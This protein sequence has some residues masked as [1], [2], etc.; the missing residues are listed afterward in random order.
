MYCPNCS[1]EV[2]QGSASCGRCGAVM[3]TTCPACGSAN[4]SGS[5]FC[6]RC[7][8][9]LIGIGEKFARQSLPVGDA[10][11]AIHPVALAERRQMTVMF[12]D[13]VGSTA[14]SSM[15]DP[16]DVREL[17]VA[18]HSC[19]RNE[20]TRFG[21]VA[22]RHVGDG[23]LIY[24]GY[25]QAHEDDAARSIYAGLAA[26]E[27]VS[28][29]GRLG[30]YKPQIRIG[31]ATGL[32]VVGD[33]IG[34]SS[35]AE[36]DVVGQTPNLAARLQTGAEPGTLVICSAT[37]RLAGAFFEYSELGPLALKGFPEPS[38]AWR[39]LRAG[40]AQT[41]S[42]AQRQTGLTSLIG[43][44]PQLEVLERLWEAARSGRGQVVC[45]T[46]EAGIGK[47]RLCT[48]WLTQLGSEWHFRLRFYCSPHHQDTPFHP[49][50]RQLERAAGISREEP[51]SVKLQKLEAALVPGDRQDETAGL[52]A[53]LLSIP[54]NDRH[55]KLPA[56]PALCREKTMEV[57]LLQSELMSR[58]RPVVAV[59]E[60]VH[61]IDPTS[62][63]LLNR[64]VARTANLPLLLIVTCRPEF[65]PSWTRQPHVTSITLG[66]LTSQQGISLVQQVAGAGF[67]KPDIVSDIVERADG[68]PLYLEE[69]TKAIVES[70]P[71]D[72]RSKEMLA[73]ALSPRTDVP[74]TLHAS[75]MARL[76]R[77][78]AAKE[79]AQIGSAIGREFSY[80][81]L[82]AV[83][84]ADHSQLTLALNSLKA[85]GLVFQHRA[86]RTATFLFK[87]ALVQN[88]AYSTLLRS[89][90]QKL[91][92]RIA[93]VLESAFAE[94]ATAQ[95]ELLAHHYTEA[96]L[97][98][99]AADCWLNAGKQALARSA[100][101]EAIARLRRGLDILA[102]TEEGTDR[103][104]LELEFQLALG[105]ALIAT[106]GHAAP[107]TG[108]VFA[109][110]REVCEQLDRPPL[111]V[112]V[113][114]GQWTH[115]LLR[116]ELPAARQRAAELLQ[117]GEA[118]RDEI[119]TLMGCRASGVTCFPLG[120]FRASRTY[121]DRGLE[122]FDPNRR[123]LYTSL[124]V[125]DVQVVM[126]YYSSWSTLYLGEF[127]EARSR[128][129]RALA[130]ARQLG[131]PYSL[132]HVLIASCL[133]ELLLHSFSDVQQPL[134]EVEAL[135]A[136]HGIF[137]FGAIATIFRGRWLAALGDPGEGIE[138]MKRGI[139][140]LRA[141]GNVLYLPT[142][143]TFLADAYGKTANH[144]QALK[145]L[146]DAAEI[147]EATQ[148]RLDEPEMYRVRGE[149]LVA[150]NSPTD[151]E[152]HFRKA[153]ALARA[154][155]GRLAELRATVSL[156][157]L[158]QSKGRDSEAR[159]LLL[160]AKDW[161]AKG[162]Y[163]PLTQARALL[164]ALI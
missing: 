147:I 21:G 71:N 135:T 76:D 82:A 9:R 159:E 89:T 131:Q 91:H 103:L 132:A 42:E 57:L 29:L 143:L 44:E 52:L 148:T 51:A 155:A 73:R 31:V 97:S 88:A 83:A 13:L 156:G 65:K 107:I 63:E 61:W 117:S 154:Q 116:A 102:K 145:E 11:R 7:G 86:G 124:T 152:K 20:I 158:W 77:L 157:T 5:N 104:R 109:R 94:I 59:F 36:R 80:E 161:F 4:Q 10:L 6:F 70:G 49:C 18:F 99:K 119:W 55:F 15:F 48:S 134:E 60:D 25:P 118:R 90:R 101:A 120:E 16:E 160:P 32:V 45:V 151:A 56:T 140:A 17:I 35:V 115:A 67:L 37:Q 100:L 54:A 47:S 84:R 79:I 137:Y 27:A 93:E 22:A 111:F 122:L 33:I 123:S 66:A 58:Q 62:L 2:S 87:H 74:P 8:N 14:A 92:Q 150:L 24:F 23:G 3:A 96:G 46:G 144:E 50:I 41:T 39:V 128:C 28:R 85:A 141:S 164:D 1:S 19:V 105:K 153:I 138:L 40:V 106:K 113:L 26:I 81:L 69:L 121:L 30:S 43:R 53:N 75:L 136:E 112:S 130:L 142:F 72:P 127:E 163:P 126:L 139:A 34:V 162:N 125:D 64:A 95:P 108:E 149:Q 38:R 12:Y 78:G 98:R 110:A 114:H 146:A 129:D 68:V 133:I